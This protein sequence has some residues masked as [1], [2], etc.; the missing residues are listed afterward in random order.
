MSVTS[1][2]PGPLGIMLPPVEDDDQIIVWPPAVILQNTRV[3]MDADGHWNGLGATEIRDQYK[4]FNP[5]AV[6]PAYGPDGHKVSR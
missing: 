5:M 4:S 2:Y 6:R 3:R 1:L